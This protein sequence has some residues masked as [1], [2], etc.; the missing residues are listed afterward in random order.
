MT[1]KQRGLP[2]VQHTPPCPACGE[3]MYLCMNCGHSE[4]TDR[5]VVDVA[6]LRTYKV[7]VEGII[8]ALCE[9][10][11]PLDSDLVIVAEGDDYIAALIGE[12]E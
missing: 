9:D 8:C 11:K 6:W 5:R 1:K 3:L 4:C 2:D 12:G 10:E 7:A